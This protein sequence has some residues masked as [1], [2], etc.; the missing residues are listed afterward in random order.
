M[1]VSVPRRI[2][3]ALIPAVACAGR[4]GMSPAAPAHTDV[5]SLTVLPK[6]A[7][8][9]P[10]QQIVVDYL[11]RRADGSRVELAPGDVSPVSPASRGEGDAEAEPRN[12]GT[13]RTSADPMRSVLTGFRLS[14]A[15]ARDTS[16]RAD[17][18]VAPSY[19]CSHTAIVLPTSD[20]YQLT[21]AHV[22]L[23]TFATPFYDSVVVAAVELEGHAPTLTVLGPREMR[24]GAI[25]IVAP[26]RNGAPGRA[27]RPGADGGSCANG[28]QG[29]DGDPGEA[30]QPGGNV[31]IIV[32][33]GSR[34]LADLVAVS[35][36][37]G[38][39]G[40]GGAPG[41]GGRANSGPRQ[42]GA[43]CST[44]AGRAGKPGRA[45][46]DGPAGSSPRVTSVIS[47]LLWSGSP[48]WNDALARRA[49]E[50]LTQFDANRRR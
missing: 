47:E 25:R 38:R 49:I 30:G 12:D 35:N 5:S 22:R 3:F 40:A 44:R 7:R 1:T 20:R 41:A 16:V 36:P 18:V 8:V 6:Q 21:T 13:W 42:A 32:Q 33:D 17:A 31:D 14:V 4:S 24:P 10:G 37:G 28:E 27:G 48:I 19:E 45:G 34:W 23:G 39:G 9:C 50:G 11:G 26:G 46:P 29:D 2:L 15:L 43:T